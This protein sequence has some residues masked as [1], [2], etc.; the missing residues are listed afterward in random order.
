M[1]IKTVALIGMGAMGLLLSSQMLEH[2]DPSD[3]RIVADSKRIDRYSKTPFM[4][5]GE[6][7]KLNFVSPEEMLEPVDLAVFAVKY[8]ALPQA[9]ADMRHQ[10]D[11]HTTIISVLNG[12]ASEDD[13]AEAYKPEQVLYVIAQGM[14]ATRNGQEMFYTRK[15][16]LAIGMVNDAQKQRLDALREYLNQMDIPIEEPEDIRRQLWSKFMFNTGVNQVVGVYGDGYGVVQKDGE[17]RRQMRQAM[18]EVLPLAEAEG[19]NLTEDD[20]EAWMK[21]ADNMSPDGKPS[22]LQDIE[23]GRPNEVGLFSGTVRQLAKKHGISV[24]LNDWLYTIL[25]QK[26]DAL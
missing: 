25:K 7:L 2:M 8:G 16:Q 4:V 21:V 1:P 12:I 24:P 17:A 13:L 6:E 20:V 11:D 9:I 26:N 22:M 15:G 3:L 10:I 5:N 14:D 18:C 19:I 23:A